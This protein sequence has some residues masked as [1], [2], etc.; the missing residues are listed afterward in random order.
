MPSTGVGIARDAV[1]RLAGI[2]A[3]YGR[4]TDRPE[5]LEMSVDKGPA[6]DSSIVRR[7]DERIEVG[8]AWPSASRFPLSLLGVLVFTTRFER[9]NR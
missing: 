6:F 1:P 5:L 8:P 4:Q 9:A 2:L 3:I 7:S